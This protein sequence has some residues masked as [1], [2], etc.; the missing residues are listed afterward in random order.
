MHSSLGLLAISL[1]TLYVSFFTSRVELQAAG[2]DDI[3]W[4]PVAWQAKVQIFIAEQHLEG[5]PGYLS[6]PFVVVG[7]D[8]RR[9]V[10]NQTLCDLSDGLLG[11]YF[12]G[13]P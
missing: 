3:D 12:A 8:R 6:R 11:R 13:V 5:K 7:H 1:S 4:L 10:S 2:E 9:A